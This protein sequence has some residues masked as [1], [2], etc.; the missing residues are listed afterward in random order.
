MGKG[1]NKT[2]KGK[3][4]NHSHGITRPTNSALR[5]ADR[6]TR[7]IILKP[8]ILKEMTDQLISFETAKLAKEKG[9]DKQCMNYMEHVYLLKI[10]YK[11]Q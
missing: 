10:M 7:G 6:E 1:D 5:K 4:F 8:N 2:K 3:R 11:W 9:F